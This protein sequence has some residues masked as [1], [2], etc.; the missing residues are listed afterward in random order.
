MFAGSCKHPISHKWGFVCLLSTSMT[1]SDLEPTSSLTRSGTDAFEYLNFDPMPFKRRRWSSPA[2][3]RIIWWSHHH[4]GDR[5]SADR[6][7]PGTSRQ[8]FA[9]VYGHD[10][11]L[12]RC[13]CCV[14][15]VTKPGFSPT[16]VWRCGYTKLGYGSLFLDIT[17]PDPN[18][19]RCDLTVQIWR[20]FWLWNMLCLS[21]FWR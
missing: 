21:T 9:C 17:Q 16:T 11:E 18:R 6:L 1:L 19:N 12:S 8:Q 3:N 13:S 2:K 5:W 20:C 4:Y 10:F 7:K 15:C 14:V